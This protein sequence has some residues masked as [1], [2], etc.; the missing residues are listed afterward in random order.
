VLDV[1]N[2]D[3]QKVVFVMNRYDKRIGITPEK[4]SESMKHEISAVI[5]FDER[6][7]IPSINRGIP[8]M[9]GDKTRPLARSYLALAEVVR[10]RINQLAELEIDSGK[11]YVSIL[12]KIGR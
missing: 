11:G 10:Q 2:L 4:I 1:L 8:F 7:V 12:G 3:R 9:M 6:V 5:P